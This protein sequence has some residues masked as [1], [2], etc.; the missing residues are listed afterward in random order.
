[1]K[2]VFLTG[3]IDTTLVSEI[4][5]LITDVIDIFM[6]EPLVWFVY[7]ALMG[8]VIGIVARL[9]RPRSR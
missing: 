2:P 7:L 8:A 3:G 1:M 5:T 6:T 9:I 4:I